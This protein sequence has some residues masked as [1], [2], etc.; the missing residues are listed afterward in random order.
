M[1]YV[2]SGRLSGNKHNTATFG[3]S[4]Q[5]KVVTTQL[6][7]PAMASFGC[8]AAVQRADNVNVLQC[9]HEHN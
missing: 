3:R 8:R 5:K 2:P 6:R 7:Q 4:L 9:I 1:S